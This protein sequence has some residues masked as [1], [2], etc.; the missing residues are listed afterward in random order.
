MQASYQ[1]R[2]LPAAW[3]KLNLG[4]NQQ[5]LPG[6]TNVDIEGFEG[7]DVTC[8]LEQ[9]WPWENDSVDYIRAFDL[10]EH[11][12]QPVH[13]MNEA[14]RVLRHGGV[15]EILVPSTDGRGAFQDPTHV[16]FW[17]QNSFLY[18]TKSKFGSLYPHLI[19]CDYEICYVD[20]APNDIRVTW[21]W[22]FC[23]A[24]KDSSCAPAISNAW[25]DALTSPKREQR[26][27]TGFRG[28]TLGTMPSCQHL[29]ANEPA[30][31]SSI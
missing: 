4:C 2:E 28:N 8:D 26:V 30:W 24:T 10:V 31:I 11:L 7:V 15:F 5:I 29:A 9:H 25:R 22:A 16:S 13:T 20:T 21:T 19:H 14:W 12:H 6:W 27:M 3:H 18:Y 23:R 1:V 17:N